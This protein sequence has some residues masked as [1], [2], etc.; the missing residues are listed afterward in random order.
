M[1]IVRRLSSCLGIVLIAAAS[2]GFFG[3]AMYMNVTQNQAQ[4]ETQIPSGPSKFKLIDTVSLGPTLTPTNQ[5]QSSP[6][7]SP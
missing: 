1:G 4:W 7:P 5:L 6:T 2:I 3:A